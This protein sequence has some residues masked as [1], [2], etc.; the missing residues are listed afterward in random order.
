MYSSTHSGKTRR[1]LPSFMD[2]SSP[3]AIF[4][5]TLERPKPSRTAT[6]AGEYHRGA[7]M[8]ECA[9][10]PC[11]LQSCRKG[12]TDPAA[13]C[14]RSGAESPWSCVHA[15]AGADRSATKPLVDTYASG[16]EGLGRVVVVEVGV[17]DGG[18]SS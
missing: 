16:R 8:P 4:I 7:R 2:R 15:E 10:F 17:V 18:G 11:L 5:F 12:G 1:Y 3:V 9:M 14:R 6:S 13:L